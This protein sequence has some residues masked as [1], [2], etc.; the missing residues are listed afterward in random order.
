MPA[1]DFVP[2]YRWLVAYRIVLQGKF[3][4]HHIEQDVCDIHCR[5]DEIDRRVKEVY[6]LDC[7]ACHR[8]VH[9]YCGETDKDAAHYVCPFCA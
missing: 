6:W 4:E 5:I 3:L 8:W 9:A 2:Y 1:Q 7:D